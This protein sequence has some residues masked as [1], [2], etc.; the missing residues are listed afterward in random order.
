MTFTRFTDARDGDRPL[1]ER[2]A[3]R[4]IRRHLVGEPRLMRVLELH[5]LGVKDPTI[6]G[7]ALGVS[8]PRAM[9]LCGDLLARL[10]TIRRALESAEQVRA[11]FDALPWQGRG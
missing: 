9:A 8:R 11:R 5:F 10:Q 2:R 3:W 7:A 6:L 4:L 1:A